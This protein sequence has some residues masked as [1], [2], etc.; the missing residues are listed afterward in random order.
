MWEGSAGAGRGLWE[1][2]GGV[3]SWR[4]MESLGCSFLGP[5]PRVS[6]IPLTTNCALRGARGWELGE[7][8]RGTRQGCLAMT[9]EVWV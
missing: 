2:P 7:Q 1:Q 9:F 8:P 5:S 3:G 6:G 4:G